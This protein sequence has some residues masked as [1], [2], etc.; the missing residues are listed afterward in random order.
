MTAREGVVF[1]NKTS[2]K[3]SSGD[4]MKKLVLFF[5]LLASTHS[6]ANSEIQSSAV[7]EVE[8]PSET[9]TFTNTLRILG[10]YGFFSSNS[11]SLDSTMGAGLDYAYFWKNDFGFTL[12]GR[13]FLQTSGTVPSTSSSSWRSA[14]QILFGIAPGYSI[15]SERT[16]T[17]FAL[18]TGALHS[19]EYESGSGG[20]GLAKT[21]FAV[22]PSVMFD[23]Y[24]S[25]NVA[26]AVG[27]LF[28][29][30]FN[31]SKPGVNSVNLGLSFNL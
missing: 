25:K 5:G 21:R 10:S 3:T 16:R 12:Q 18:L 13:Y 15:H 17:V 22:G 8:R 11:T 27:G 7:H 9:S 20:T 19:D 29:Y 1:S 6:F 23:F 31:D 14:T 28:A 2:T 30:T 24:I 26:I 4:E